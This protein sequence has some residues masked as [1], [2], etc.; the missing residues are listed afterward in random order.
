MTTVAAYVPDLI[1]RSKVAAAG[2][3]IVFVD[4]PRALLDTPADIVVVDLMRPGVLD[5]LP[6]LHGRRVIGFGR[7]TD[8]ARLEAAA[9]AGCDE[10]LP[11]SSFF[12]R[13]AE[14][15]TPR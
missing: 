12:P 11:R 4:E 3:E 10:V 7:H 5:V 6:A 13:V 15:L 9:A 1:D 8:R 14:L 2:R